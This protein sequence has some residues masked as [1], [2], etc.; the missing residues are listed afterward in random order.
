MTLTDII[1]STAKSL[2]VASLISLTSGCTGIYCEDTFK[3]PTKVDCNPVTRVI[4]G[5]KVYTIPQTL[6][7]GLYANS[8]HAYHSTRNV[9]CAMPITLPLTF[10]EGL[11]NVTT[12]TAINIVSW[13]P[14]E[15][16]EG[17]TGKTWKHPYMPFTSA[18][19]DS[20]ILDNR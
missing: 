13:I 3:F 17:I 9:P 1:K 2:G 20:E 4:P 6:V 15:I 10:A 16:Y 5:D 7:V 18:L 8:L 12:D 14:L 19:L 11:L